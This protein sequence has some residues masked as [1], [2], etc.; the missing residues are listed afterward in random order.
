MLASSES[1]GI[2]SEPMQSAERIYPGQENDQKQYALVLYRSPDIYSKTERRLIKEN[3]YYHRDPTYMLNGT[4]VL[5]ETGEKISIT[6]SSSNYS[7]VM[8]L[9]S[10]TFYL[11][12]SK[13]ENGFIKVRL[14]EETYW[15]SV[16]E[17]SAVGLELI[18][19]KD[20]FRVGSDYTI[21]A[22]NS[23]K[24][25]ADA[26]LSSETILTMPAGYRA[27]INPND[28]Y[29]QIESIFIIEGQWMQVVLKKW[30][31]WVDMNLERPEA[32][33][34]TGWIKFLDTDG[35]VQIFSTNNFGC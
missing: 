24:L 1:I 23:L 16:S 26:D 6:F 4:S 12:F 29:Y 33:S 27:Q 10:E 21:T 7:S 14:A 2:F 11:T 30:E 5:M 19:W 34:I 22:L 28:P 32:D 25:K 18:M 17:I 15:L 3:F 31:T 9:G 13:K 35:H 8:H 20:Y